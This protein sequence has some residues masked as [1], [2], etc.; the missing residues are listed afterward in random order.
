MTD[1]ITLVAG[2]GASVDNGDSVVQ[3]GTNFRLTETI[4]V[5]YRAIEFKEESLFDTSVGDLFG[6]GSTTHALRIS[7][8]F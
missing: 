2:V 4:G 6:I 7:K 3:V 1:R 5:E 8:S